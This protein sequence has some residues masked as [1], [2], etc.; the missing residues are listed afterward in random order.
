MTDATRASEPSDPPSM[1][2]RC[3]QCQFEAPKEEVEHNPS[4]DRWFT[5]PA[6]GHKW[7][8]SP[9]ADSN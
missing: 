1:A 5:C 6:C 9:I 2:F 8:V 3:P 4:T 7:S